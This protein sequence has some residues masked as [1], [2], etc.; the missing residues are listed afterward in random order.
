VTKVPVGGAEVTVMRFA[1]PARGPTYG[2]DA[3]ELTLRHAG[4][5]DQS[6]VATFLLGPGEYLVPFV[7]REGYTYPLPEFSDPSFKPIVVVSGKSEKVTLTAQANGRIRGRVQDEYGDPVVNAQV[8]ALAYQP[9]TSPILLG[10]Y[11]VVAEAQTDDRGEY[12]LRPLIPGRYAIRVIPPRS[13]SDSDYF[14]TYYPNASQFDQAL[15][16]T[17]AP[18][19]SVSAANINLRSGRTFSV[20]GTLNPAGKRYSTSIKVFNHGCNL[21]YAVDDTFAYNAQIGDA[22]SFSVAAIPPGTY[23][24]VGEEQLEGTSQTAAIGRLEVTVSDRNLTDVI[25]PLKPVRDVIGEIRTEANITLQYIELRPVGQEFASRK[26]LTAQ[27]IRDDRDPNKARFRFKNVLPIE[28]AVVTSSAAYLI[29]SMTYGEQQHGNGRF[30][31]GEADGELKLEVGYATSRIEGDIGREAQLRITVLPADP[32]AVPIDRAK[33]SVTDEKGRFS[34]RVPAG[35]Y[36]LYLWERF[37]QSWSAAP[38]F[39]LKEFLGTVVTV[40]DSTTTT[41]RLPIITA[42]ELDQAKARAQ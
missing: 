41:V 11:K 18:G 34:I 15:R 10:P 33:G 32:A 37:D 5:T 25:F 17:L 20:S 26:V 35:S 19:A 8:A 30:N 27:V 23:C 3:K 36:K 9:E 24:M 21:K 2:V 29:K 14:M 13:R 6:G 38:A 16:L 4:R 1:S 12:Q 39:L 22:G 42:R 31:P 40:G 28:Y 7:T